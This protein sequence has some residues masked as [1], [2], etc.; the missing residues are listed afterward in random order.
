MQEITCSSLNF[1]QLKEVVCKIKWF[2]KQFESEGLT[3]IKHLGY[4]DYVL[5]KMDGLHLISSFTCFNILKDELN[6]KKDDC[7]FTGNNEPHMAPDAD[8]FWEDIN[9]FEGLEINKMG[10]LIESNKWS[11]DTDVDPCPI[12]DDR[13]EDGVV[14]VELSTFNK[15]VFKTTNEMYAMGRITSTAAKKIMDALA[16]TPRV[17][18]D[19]MSIPY[20]SVNLKFKKLF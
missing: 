1:V 5:L 4:Q 11:Y 7:D 15:C 16:K 12:S 10:E 18:A 14:Y 6:E 3:G 8:R 9:Y 17:D 2:E 19:I 20:A 13:I